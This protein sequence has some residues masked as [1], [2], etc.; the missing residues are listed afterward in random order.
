MTPGARVA[1]AIAILDEILAGAAA[2]Q[3]LTAWGRRSRYA[4]S[5]DR[6]A[7]RDHVFDALRNLQGYQALAGESGWPPG[8]RALL[9]GAL[10]AGGTDPGEIFTG[11]G[12]APP[13][14]SAEEMAQTGSADGVFNLPDWLRDE[15]VSALGKEAAMHQARLLANRAP[16][17]I[18]ANAARIDRDTLRR[19]LEGEGFELRDNPL[20][21]DALTVIGEARGLAR[22][23]AFRDGLFEMQDATSQAV[24]AALDLPSGGR[25]LDYCAGG[26]GKA[27]ALSAR[28]GSVTAHDADPRRMKDLPERAR[29]A[30]VRIT[31]EPDATALP[32]GVFDLVLLDAPCSGSGTWRRAPEAK[33]QFTR[34]RLQRLVATQRAILEDARSF[35]APGGTLAYATCS[36]LPAENGAQCAWFVENFADWKLVHQRTWSVSDD[37]DGFFLARFTPA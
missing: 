37:G 8:G 24:I 7:V 11:H 35:V 17:T 3:V 6:A 32:H 28:G 1:A 30:G 19:F 31:V 13:P 33:W 15:F 20:S 2:E 14:L 34:D 25:V 29:R 22:C 27:L 4:G 16:V 12:H 21:L 5:K 9:I 10:R 36:I 18:R 26:G 23:A